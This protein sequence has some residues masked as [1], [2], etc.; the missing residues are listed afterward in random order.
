[1][2]IETEIDK[3][4]DVRTKELFAVIKV[5]LKTRGLLTINLLLSLKPNLFTGCQ[6]DFVKKKVFLKGLIFKKKVFATKK[7]VFH[8]KWIAF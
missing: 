4:Y 7:K 1:M 6:L 8:A 3:C 2:E 5:C